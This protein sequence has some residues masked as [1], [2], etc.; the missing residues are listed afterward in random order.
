MG[1]QLVIR[2]NRG[3]SLTHEG[4][5]FLEYAE[6]ALN[7]FDRLKSVCHHENASEA[8]A[9][10]IANMRF[11]YVNAAVSELYNN[12]KG[13]PIQL[14]IS[15]ADRDGVINLISHGDCDIGVIHL[16]NCYKKDILAQI[17]SK[18]LQFHSLPW[19][20]PWSSSAGAALF[21]IWMK[22]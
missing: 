5:L 4:E 6:P 8:P 18:D 16:L 13:D 7:Q 20:I 3:V 15:E 11:R 19:T 2:N 17:K 14:F 21:S 10:S 12:H 9:F 22:K 1:C